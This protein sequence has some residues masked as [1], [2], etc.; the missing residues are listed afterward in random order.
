MS[1]QFA[2]IVGS[3]FESF[4]SSGEV[5]RIATRFVTGKRWWAHGGKDPGGDQ[6]AVMYWFELN[7]EN[8]KVTWIPHAFD[9]NSGIGTQLFNVAIAWAR[10]C[11]LDHIQTTVWSANR[12]AKEF[13]C[14]QGFRPLRD[15][16]E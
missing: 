15:R 2:I 1:Q 5:H 13:Y 16:F 7:R 10:Q 4:T 12:G 14:R 11:G 9:H 6:P 8:G 3:G